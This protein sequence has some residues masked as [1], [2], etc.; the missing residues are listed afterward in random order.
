MVFGPA[1]VLCIGSEK[2]CSGHAPGFAEGSQADHRTVTSQKSENFIDAAG[3][4]GQGARKPKAHSLM[5]MRP[6]GVPALAPDGEPSVEIRPG[7]MSASGRSA[8]FGLRPIAALLCKNHWQ[9]VGVE[10]AS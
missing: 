8:R 2:N 3:A 5:L 7:K 4:C 1:G 10:D 9:F 6:V